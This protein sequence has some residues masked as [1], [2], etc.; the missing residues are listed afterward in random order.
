MNGKYLGQ[1]I[2]VYK[3]ILQDI[4]DFI[5]QK[6]HVLSILSSKLSVHIIIELSKY[7]INNRV[8]FII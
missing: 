6:L 3:I 7:T 5:Y 8:R 1:I 4:V 2:I